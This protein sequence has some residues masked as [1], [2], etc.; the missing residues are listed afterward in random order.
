M[1]QYITL[2]IQT[3]SVVAIVAFV[4]VGIIGKIAGRQFVLFGLAGASYSFSALFISQT[5]LL[6]YL[7]NNR[8][9]PLDIAGLISYFVVVVFY[10]SLSTLFSIALTK[11]LPPLKDSYSLE[12]ETAGNMVERTGALIKDGY[13]VQAQSNSHVILARITNIPMIAFQLL[14]FP[15]TGWIVLL[16]LYYKF[17]ANTSIVTLTT[18]HTV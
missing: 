14:L 10:A 7:L 18:N 8:P 6:V 13:V 2:Y 17:K 3:F 15:V 1:L 5:S 11:A 4:V 12:C 16:F 9:G